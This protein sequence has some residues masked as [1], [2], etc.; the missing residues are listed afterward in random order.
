M[1]TGAGGGFRRRFPC[2]HLGEAR[3]REARLRAVHALATLQVFLLLASLLAPIPVAAAES[4]AMPATAAATPAVALPAAGSSGA[5][6]DVVTANAG[7][8][9]SATV[10]TAVAIAPSVLV[11]NT[12]GNAVAGVSVTFAVAAGGGSATETSAI[13]DAAGIATVG[14]WTLGDTAGANSLTATSS[15]LS[16]SPVTFTATG[17]PDAPSQLAFGQQPTPTTSGTQISPPVTVLV[18]DQYGNTVT[19]DSSVVTISSSDANL[20]VASTL[21]VA[22]S[23]GIATFSNLLPT[24]A[25]SAHTLSAADGLL[26]G[27][28]SAAF[29]VDP[30]PASHLAFGQQPSSGIYGDAMTPS[31]DVRVL[32]A[33]GN[34]TSSTVTVTLSITSGTGTTGA[35]IL[36]TGSAAAVAG[37]A[38]FTGM[39]V[40]SV[41]TGYTLDATSDLLTTATSASFNVAARPLT[42]TASNNSKLYGTDA[43]AL[44]G[45]GS[46]AFTSSGLANGDV[47]GSVTLADTNSCAPL[48]TAAG[49]VC[50]ITPS[51]AVFTTGSSANYAVPSYVAG[52][53]QIGTRPVTVTAD[54]GQHKT[55]GAA[56]PV[57]TYR[58]TSSSLVG[59]DALAGALARAPGE[60]VAGGPYA[61]TLGTL[62]SLNPNYA[63]TLA[64]GATFAITPAP[65]TTTISFGV[66]S[67]S[68]VPYKGSTYVVSTPHATGPGGLNAPLTPI[69]TGECMLPSNVPGASPCTATAKYAGSSDYLPSLGSATI[70][71]QPATTVVLPTPGITPLAA[72]MT[73]ASFP[74][75]FATGGGTYPARSFDLRYRRAAYNGTFQTVPTEIDGVVSSRFQFTG[76][77]G[78]TY[79]F[80][81]RSYDPYH[82]TTGR[83]SAETCTAIPLDDRSLGLSTGWSKRTGTAYYNNTYAYAKTLYAYATR[84]LVQARRIALVAT[85]CSSCGTIRV[86]W[87]GRLINTVSLKSTTT[88]YRKVILLDTF[89][90]VQKGTLKL[91][92]ATS[93][94]NI[95]LDGVAIKRV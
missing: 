47:I 88:V 78:S 66:A 59:T 6:S 50:A 23:S 26:T 14:T 73:S 70:T 1:T 82:H 48:N 29:A 17:T 33:S 93:G 2:D 24:L 41:G 81:V 83:W 22:A 76:L 15:G 12:F 77:A 28:T 40:S 63:V 51:A 84:T 57:L 79:C 68:P 37:I 25:G 62:A 85:T 91:V 31:V 16:G 9:Q 86:Y 30:G 46:T 3:L 21:A 39:S 10:H 38:T 56:D 13:T 67:G 4:A 58:V 32:D 43:S 42:I 87:N 64:P 49:T 44:F 55:Y 69:Y 92:V 18:Q 54:A 8:A 61:I 5:V 7:D 65:T 95:Y 52:T 11:A 80:S 72:Y 35:T 94:K 45:A 74:L 19:T 34:L 36:A 75:T 60:T 53:L 20:D 27:A 90:V 89:S 71:I